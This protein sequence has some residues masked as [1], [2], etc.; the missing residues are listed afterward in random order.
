M[1]SRMR[2][3]DEDRNMRAGRLLP[4]ADDDAIMT[5]LMTVP[6]PTTKVCPCTFKECHRICLRHGDA[7]S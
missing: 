2:L 7:L 6:P 3:N 5:M 4:P 1:P